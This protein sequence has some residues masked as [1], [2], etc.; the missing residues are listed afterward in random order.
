M[1]LAL[2]ICLTGGLLLAWTLNASAEILLGGS[3][4]VGRNDFTAAYNSG[5][6]GGVSKSADTLGF[7]GALNLLGTHIGLEYTRSAMDDYSFATAGLRVGWELGPEL[8]KVKPFAGYEEYYFKNETLAAG[9]DNT[10]ASP[11]AGLE[12]AA[13]LG[14]WAL[15]GTGC[16]PLQTRYSNGIIHDDHA[17]LRYL[18]FG[19]TY[20]PLPLLD[21]FLRYRSLSADSKVVDI[22][23]KGYTV[24]AEIS[25]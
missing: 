1:K 21:L 12:L 22:T 20:S 25:F 7:N 3:L 15:S 23:A 18:K 24:G 11:V 2:I 9:G 8:L 5:L 16:L 19:L 14:K 6:V 10:Y 4:E 17:D 13:R